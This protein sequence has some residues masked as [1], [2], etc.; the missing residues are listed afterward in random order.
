MAD[1]YLFL[2]K[3]HN[4]ISSQKDEHFFRE[5][6]KCVNT[7]L[8]ALVLLSPQVIDKLTLDLKVIN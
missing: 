7:F 2:Q 4:Q 5:Y 1:Q 6:D 8:M 3:Y